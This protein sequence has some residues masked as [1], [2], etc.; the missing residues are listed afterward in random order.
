VAKGITDG[1]LCYINNEDLIVNATSTPS[2]T[3]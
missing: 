2:P 1:I 3:P